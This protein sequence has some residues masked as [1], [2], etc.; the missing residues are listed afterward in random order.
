MGTIYKRDQILPETL[1]YDVSTDDPEQFFEIEHIYSVDLD[2]DQ[3]IPTM[4]QMAGSELS[5]VNL[6]NL[7]FDKVSIGIDI[8]QAPLG[9]WILILESINL[10]TELEGLV[11]PAVLRTDIINIEIVQ[12][13]L[14]EEAEPECDTESDES[15]CT[16]QR[17]RERIVDVTAGIP[18]SWSLEDLID[19]DFEYSEIDVKFSPY[20]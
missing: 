2:D 18:K 20:L 6:I 10:M 17:Y 14:I 8:A 5:F 3:L 15:E 11:E 7:S 19:T 13:E 12:T 9:H 1:T 4:R 16:E